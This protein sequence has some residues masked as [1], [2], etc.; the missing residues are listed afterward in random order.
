MIAKDLASEWGISEDTVRR[1]LRELAAAGKLQRVHGGALPSSEA[2]GDL[3]VREQV[4]V[5][6]KLALGRRP[7]RGQT[8]HGRRGRIGREESPA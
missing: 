7:S 8:E 3:R 2:V 1:D 4:S 5:D 6:D